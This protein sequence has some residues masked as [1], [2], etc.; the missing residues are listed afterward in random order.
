MPGWIFSEDSWTSS[1]NWTKRTL[2]LGAFAGAISAACAGVLGLADY[3]LF[4]KPLE[5]MYFRSYLWAASPTILGGHSDYSLLLVQVPGRNSASEYFATDADVVPIDAGNGLFRLTAD[6]KRRGATGLRW[7]T[8]SKTPD[9]EAYW[10]LRDNIYS[11][12]S[13]WDLWKWPRAAGYLVF[14]GLMVLGVYLDR[15]DIAGK[16]E[17]KN[18]KGPVLVT[19]EEFNLVKQGDGIG[20][21]TTPDATMLRIRAKDEWLHCS[22]MGDTGTGKSVLI[23]QILDQVRGRGEPA[24]VYD[25]AMEF[26]PRYYREGVDFILNPLDARSPFWSPSDELTNPHDAL[27]IAESLF[28]EK[29]RE[30]RFFTES[31]RRIFAELLKFR[32]TPEE[33]IHWMSHPEEIDKRLAGTPLAPFIAT[34]AAPQRSGVLSELNMVA[35]ALQLLPKR[36]DTKATWSAADWARERQGWLFISSTPETNPVLLPLMSMWLDMLVLRLSSGDP[37]WAKAHPVWMV[38]DEVANLQKLPKLETALTQSRKSNVRIVL[39]FQGRSQLDHLYG[40]KAEVMLS[41]PATKIFLKTTEPRAA[42]WISQCIGD[43]TIERLREGVTAAV[44]DWRD[45]MNYSM[46]RRIEPL[47]MDSQV[48]GLEPLAGYLK[49][50]NHVVK[51]QFSPDPKPPCAEPFIPRVATPPEPKPVAATPVNGSPAAQPKVNGKGSTDSEVPTGT[52]TEVPPDSS[53]EDTSF[54]IWTY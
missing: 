23:T 18:L 6:A 54:R 53:Q 4:W 34:D 30:H 21:K 13:V 12:R 10:E 32:P 35:G 47:V 15:K 28:P 43:I 2:L 37:N 7:A 3:G 24:I 5:K 40:L 39:G 25:P 46:D 17:G 16:R 44:H 20:I 52:G 29:E 8:Y 14:V 19:P 26:I 27:A 51:I 11:D 41:Q 50:D 42:K 1:R 48:A 45:S 36:E 22:I 49:S 9:I 31:P 38:I 33:L